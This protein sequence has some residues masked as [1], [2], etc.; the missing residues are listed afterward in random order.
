MPLT[1]ERFKNNQRLQAAADN[2]PVMKKFETD[3]DAVRLVQQ[4]LIDLKIND[5]LPANVN[6]LKVNGAFDD[7]MYIAVKR[8]QMR[9][10]KELYDKTGSPDGRLGR[11][12]LL[13][14]DELFGGKKDSSP[15]QRHQLRPLPPRRPLPLRPKKNGGAPEDEDAVVWSIITAVLPT[16]AGNNQVVTMQDAH[17]QL[18]A[19][20]AKDLMNVYLAAAEHYM[21]AR[22]TVAE[23][24]CPAHQ[25]MMLAIPGYTIA[26]AILGLVNQQ[27]RLSTDGTPVTPAN[28][29]AVRW[30]MRGA[31]AGMLN[32]VADGGQQFECPANYDEGGLPQGFGPDPWCPVR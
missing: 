20:R 25:I 26:K 3:R 13:K 16:A 11:K 2:N 7:T 1:S 8:F 14:L 15:E 6:P 9:F 23:G 31:N 30:G 29:L 28:V 17:R 27:D 18:F 12:T 32:F 22:L 4:A 24:G 10:P 5:G 19:M 21:Y